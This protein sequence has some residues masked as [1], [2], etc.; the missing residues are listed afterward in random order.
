MDFTIIDSIPWAELKNAYG[1]ADSA[2]QSLRALISNNEDDVDEAIYGFLH[3]EACHQYTTYSCT[4]YVV[5]CVLLILEHKEFS[6][7]EL[8]EI[9]GFIR[10]CTNSAKEN[11]MLRNEIL[12]G[13]E[14]FQKYL[15]KPGRP[16]IESAKLLEFCSEY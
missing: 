16:R 12:A 1:S 14:C 15:K 11:E 7:S 4:P 3:S 13:R 2:P 5:K 9:L 6:E 8:A 10:A